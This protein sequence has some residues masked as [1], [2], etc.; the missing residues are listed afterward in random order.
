MPQRAPLSPPLLTAAC[1]LAALP[2]AWIALAADALASGVIG[3]L[4]GFPLVRLAVSPRFLLVTVQATGGDHAPGLWAIALLTGPL[5]AA[6]VGLALQFVVELVRSGPWLRVL[7]LEW[8]VFALLRLPAL[9]VAGVLPRGH[10][11]V[12]DLYRRLGEPQSG[13]WAV[14]LLA[15]LALAGAGALASRRAVAAARDWMRIDGQ[16]FRRHLVRAVVGYPALVS[17]AAWSALS[18]WAPAAWMAAWLLV[19]FLTLMILTA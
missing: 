18:P 13:R 12:D 11:P 19:T 16:P 8:A 6:A 7:S 1:I 17:L 5:L 9:L 10:G 4:V 3:N 14:G 15:L 2:A